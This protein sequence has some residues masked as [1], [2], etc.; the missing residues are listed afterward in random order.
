MHRS[1]GTDNRNSKEI[2][3]CMSMDV[4]VHSC[5]Q[6]SDG[7]T[8]WM[9]GEAIEDIFYHAKKSQIW[10]LA[11]SFQKWSKDSRAFTHWITTMRVDG[12]WWI[13]KLWASPETVGETIDVLKSHGYKTGVS[14]WGACWR[15]VGC[16]LPPTIDPPVARILAMGDWPYPHSDTTPG[17]YPDP[18]T[19]WDI[20]GAYPWAS[21]LGLPASWTLKVSDEKRPADDCV[22]LLKRWRCHDTT[23]QP[24]LPHWAREQEEP[25][26]IFSTNTQCMIPVASHRVMFQEDQPMPLHWIPGESANRLGLDWGEND[27]VY[28]LHWSNTIDIAPAFDRVREVFPPHL[29]K[30]VLASHWGIW[31]KGSGCKWGMFEYG[32]PTK[33]GDGSEAVYDLPASC[34]PLYAGLLQARVSERVSKYGENSPRTYVDSVL[35]PTGVSPTPSG[36]NLGDWRIKREFPNGLTQPEHPRRPKPL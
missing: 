14:T 29:A 20:K 30:M 22:F 18:Y 6:V 1:E 17:R 15:K 19:E 28:A 36:N 2:R 4:R 7:D 33:K 32:K 24:Y 16:F 10:W 35:L 12:K 8:I 11:D 3:F 26:W 23:L 31:S 9:S 25:R 27:V 5:G 34:N 21:T 13:R